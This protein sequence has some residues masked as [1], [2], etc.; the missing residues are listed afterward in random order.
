M[1]LS[2]FFPPWD[3]FEK[4]EEDVEVLTGRSIDKGETRWEL[5]TAAAELAGDRHGLS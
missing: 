5:T 4:R 3:H 2:R 1:E